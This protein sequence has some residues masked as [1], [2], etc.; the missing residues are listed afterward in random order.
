MNNLNVNKIPQYS[1]SEALSKIQS[2]GILLDVR[3]TEEHSS[4]AI[5]DS[6]HIPLQE[7]KNRL[8]ELE[9]FRTREIICYCASGY[10]S[11][12]AAQ[13]LMQEGFTV[14]NLSGGIS[15]WNIP[16]HK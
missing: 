5:K 15:A 8:H 14:A 13:I 11:N 3:T 12:S 7:I 2:G 4:N 10:R 6:L 9:E 16:L 1:P